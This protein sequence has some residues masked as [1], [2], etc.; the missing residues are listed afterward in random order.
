MAATTCVS[1]TCGMTEKHHHDPDFRK[2]RQYWVRPFSQLL[3][4]HA[5][6]EKLTTEADKGQPVYC[7]MPTYFANVKENYWNRRYQRP[8]SFGTAVGSLVYVY[9]EEQWVLGRIA[10]TGK[11]GSRIL[12]LLGNGGSEIWTDQWSHDRAQHMLKQEL[13]TSPLP[14]EDFI[15]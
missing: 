10:T 8:W 5:E 11:R 13:T 1:F 3:A 7:F 15:Q 14:W 2:A 6:L 4:R 9:D 12:T